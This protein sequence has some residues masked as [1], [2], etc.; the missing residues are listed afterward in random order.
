MLMCLCVLW[1]PKYEFWCG[2]IR[3]WTIKS[4]CYWQTGVCCRIVRSN[5]WKKELTQK[6][7]YKCWQLE[8][9]KKPPGLGR[10]PSRRIQTVVQL[11]IFVS[12]EAST[13]KS[14]QSSYWVCCRAVL[15]SG[16]IPYLWKVVTEC[17]CIGYYYVM[18]DY[19]AL[20]RAPC[21][22]IFQNFLWGWLCKHLQKKW[23][24]KCKIRPLSDSLIHFLPQT[25]C[26]LNSGV[27]WTWVADALFW[28]VR[29]ILFTDLFPGP[30]V[31]VLCCYSHKWQTFEIVVPKINVSVMV[32]AI[33]CLCPFLCI[34]MLGM[35]VFFD[36][37]SW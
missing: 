13:M 4:L 10:P 33:E 34:L 7:C 26:F 37:I 36:Y 22:S 18:G 32:Y 29:I 30:C 31:F 27:D 11:F 5:D 25:A 1:L 6:G 28:Y 17:A 9:G 20:L 8:G 12:N 16:N 23:S 14:W 15:S 24:S 19:W 21:D 3:C 2:R 35:L